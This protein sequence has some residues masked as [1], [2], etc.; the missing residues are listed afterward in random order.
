MNRELNTRLSNIKQSV[1]TTASKEISMKLQ[2]NKEKQ[3]EIY[4]KKA[5]DL[6][7]V[8][9]GATVRIHGGKTWSEKA[10]VTG[11]SRMP[12]SY[13]IKTESGR[14]LHRNRQHLLLS[15][16]PFKPTTEVGD[17]VT[18]THTSSGYPDKS[19][20]ENP[21]TSVDRSTSDSYSSR[22]RSNIKPPERY[23]FT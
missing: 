22:L 4:N 8:P 9:A 19:Q 18:P 5:K 20:E 13:N 16:E 11:K 17:D 14:I 3:K 15:K 12:R 1:N 23:G 10:W 6:P 21:T 2:I 7:I